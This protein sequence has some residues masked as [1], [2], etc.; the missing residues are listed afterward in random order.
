[1]S[2]A[3]LARDVA[4][5]TAAFALIAVWLLHR[6]PIWMHGEA[7]EG[8]VVQ[9]IVTHGRW[10]LPRRNGALPSK[11]PLFHWVAAAAAHVAGLSDATLR[12]P[13]AL[14]AWVMLLA[15]FA[16]GV[17]LGGRRVGWLAVGVLAGTTTF[18]NAAAEARTDML[19]S[20]C[21]TVALAAFLFWTL[22][23][24]AAA[25][26]ACWAAVTLAVLAKGPAGAALPVLVIGAFALVGERRPDRLGALWSWPLAVGA[27]VVAVGWYA[28]AYRSGGAEFLHVQLLQENLQRFVGRGEFTHA[29]W[30]R[31]LRM[32]LTLMTELLPWSLV[33]PWAAIAWW[34]GRREDEGGR[35]L[36]VWWIAI[37]AFFTL[38]AGKR[39]VYLLP[40][41]PAVALLAARALAAAA[42]GDRLFGRLA[43]PAGLRR[44]WPAA[45]ALALVAVAMVVFD[46]G[47]LAANQ[48]TREGRAA[49]HSLV[50][51][52]REVA[53]LVGADEPLRVG[54][55]LPASDVYILGYR[56]ARPLPREPVACATRGWSLL[57]SPGAA[58]AGRVVAVAHAQ[59]EA[60]ALVACPDV[61]S[62]QRQP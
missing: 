37:L 43:V 56:L 33:L 5:L 8:L 54:P 3:R 20:A 59:G 60:V 24:R 55:G 26:V 50:P 12:L 51:F 36:H 13:S 47:L 58:R 17:R 9:D 19:F 4:L 35:F 62:A 38:A 6:P 29:R 57:A 39:A 32:E 61:A 23:D 14:A 15:T 21:V 40:L 41:Y 52:A 1:V 25:R 27:A 53:G 31:P 49:R 46:A 42:D 45:P 16:V 2:R 7:R 48:A 44:R 11:P 18:W 30:R 28:A 10:V 22:D 34:R